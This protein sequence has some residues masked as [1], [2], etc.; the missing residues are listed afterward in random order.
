M[1][2]CDRSNGKAHSMCASGCSRGGIA[3]QTSN[4]GA[5]SHSCTLL[6]A[7][8]VCMVSSLAPM[9]RC[10]ASACDQHK[11]WQQGFSFKLLCWP[12]WHSLL[13]LALFGQKLADSRAFNGNRQKRALS[14][15]CC[16]SLQ[17]LQILQIVCKFSMRTCKSFKCCALPTNC[18][19]SLY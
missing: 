16:K 18:A 3:R 8:L 6:V 15:I 13:K 4:D 9:M 5:I 19:C 7:F 10:N 17:I 12:M 2:C 1:A 11:Q 14:V